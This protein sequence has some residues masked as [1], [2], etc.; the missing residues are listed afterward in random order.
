MVQFIHRSIILFLLVLFTL[1]VLCCQ[2]LQFVQS[3]IHSLY[4]YCLSCSFMYQFSLFIH[5]RRLIAIDSF[6]HSFILFFVHSFQ[7]SSIHIH[8][9]VLTLLFIRS[10]FCSLIVIYSW[11]YAITCLFCFS[12]CFSAV[13]LC[14]YCLLSFSLIFAITAFTVCFQLLSLFNLLAVLL[15]AA[16]DLLQSRLSLALFFPCCSYSLSSLIH[17]RC[18]MISVV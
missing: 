4:A 2:L 8:I 9:C 11:I 16:V 13:N 17:C 18:F 5:I 1:L 7:F 14:D 10:F 3:F 15:V 6:F 12:C